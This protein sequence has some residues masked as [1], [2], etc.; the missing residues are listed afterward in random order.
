MLRSV[1]V[2]QILLKPREG[3]YNSGSNL[4]PHFS[5]KATNVFNSKLLLYGK[6]KAGRK[7]SQIVINTWTGG[8][9]QATLMICEEVDPGVTDAQDIFRVLPLGG[10]DSEKELIIYRRCQ[11]NDVNLQMLFVKRARCG[12][13]I[14]MVRNA[15]LSIHRIVL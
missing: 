10:W 9:S 2:L 4:F 11:Q 7:R 12:L 14:A 5:V 6:V 8:T 13:L 1:K 3:R 15:L